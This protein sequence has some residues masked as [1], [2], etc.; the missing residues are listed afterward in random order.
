MSMLQENHTEIFNKSLPL[1]TKITI[2]STVVDHQSTVNHFE[3]RSLWMITATI[4]TIL[5][6]CLICYKKWK[7][8]TKNKKYTN[9][10][11]YLPLEEISNTSSPRGEC[12]IHQTKMIMSSNATYDRQH[13]QHLCLPRKHR[14]LYRNE[15]EYLVIGY[16]KKSSD[17]H[18]PKAIKMLCTKYYD[19]VHYW[20]IKGNEY[21]EVMNCEWAELNGPIFTIKNIQFQLLLDRE[22]FYG[23]DPEGY[24]Q[25][26]LKVIQYP[27]KLHSLQV[28]FVL[29]CEQTRNEF[30][31]PHTF[32]FRDAENENSPIDEWLMNDSCG[33]EQH[34]APVKE[35]ESF[36]MITLGV[37]VDIQ[38]IEYYDDAI[39]KNYITPIQM[40]TKCEYIW[41][42]NKEMIDKL[43]SLDFEQFI[44]SERFD[45]GCWGMCMIPNGQKRAHE[46]GK[47][48]GNVALGLV[49]YKLPFGLSHLGVKYTLKCIETNTIWRDVED[50]MING[51][52][53]EF[54]HYWPNGLFL[55]KQ[56]DDHE[57]LTFSVSLEIT[58]V[59]SPEY[60]YP[61]IGRKDWDT[62]GI[63]AR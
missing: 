12:K 50:Y 23:A 51:K 55:T 6:L 9:N 7:I 42:I 38:H 48:P 16:I 30:R 8:N 39:H 15:R 33:W 41:N 63:R 22:Q 20:E 17:S 32:N 58:N 3:Y 2:I 34:C 43:K 19:D 24:I 26:Y 52:Y 18:I 46:R 40:N 47:S 28:Y 61:L 10:N 13:K 36:N 25:L 56:L 35:C 4:L 62:F 29:Y 11:H 49:L 21:T 37:M 14:L 57:T 53:D 1:S 45:D 44:C 31:K 27:A 54:V 59:C 5:C 60:G